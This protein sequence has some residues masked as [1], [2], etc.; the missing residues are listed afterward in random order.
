MKSKILRILTLAGLSAGTTLY[1]GSCVSDNLWR[2]NP[3][4]TILSTTI[5]NPTDWYARIFDAPDWSVDPTC[6]I[7]FQCG[8]GTGVPGGGSPGGNQ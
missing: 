6:P 3:C 8:G 4:G 7:P 5:C 2:F 1:G